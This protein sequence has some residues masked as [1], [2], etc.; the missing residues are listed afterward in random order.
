MHRFG[1]YDEILHG[2]KENNFFLFLLPWQ[3]LAASVQQ[4]INSV[5]LLAQNNR[6]CKLAKF[7]PLF[8]IGSDAVKLSATSMRRP[9]IKTLSPSKCETLKGAVVVPT[10]FSRCTCGPLRTMAASGLVDHALALDH[11][12]F[13]TT[14]CQAAPV[15]NQIFSCILNELKKQ[16][17]NAKCLTWCPTLIG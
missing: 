11:S 14:T 12:I 10:F 16:E 2:T 5:I 1:F 7:K 6:G 3:K 13:M 9:W 17:V 15:F 4:G 8:L